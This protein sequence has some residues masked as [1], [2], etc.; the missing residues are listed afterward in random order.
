[1]RRTGDL[2]SRQLKTAKRA[3]SRNKTVAKKKR[4]HE[5]YVNEVEGMNFKK[6]RCTLLE[7]KNGANS[8]S[9]VESWEN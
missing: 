6:L 8:E 9:F 7:T 3:N 5:T 1:M 2:I 4:K